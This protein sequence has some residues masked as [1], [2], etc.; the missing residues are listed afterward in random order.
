MR[1]AFKSVPLFLLLAVILVVSACAPAAQ[2]AAKPAAKAGTETQKEA[3]KTAPQSSKE[4][5][6][7]GMVLAQTG[8]YGAVGGG[9]AKAIQLEVD[10]VN[11]AGGV[12][13]HP[14]QLI[15][16]DDQSKAEENTALLR[17]AANDDKVVA[18]F[19]PIMTP[20]IAAALPVI[21]EIKVPTIA[22]GSVATKPEDPYI[23]TDINAID[24]LMN[25]YLDFA[26]KKGFKKVVTLTTT[27]DLSNQ[28]VKLVETLSPK[29]GL[30]LVGQERFAQTDQDV[31]PQL[32]K[33]KALNPDLLISW[34]T[35][36]AAVLLY[37]NSR[38]LGF[39]APLVY[40]TAASTSQW[41]KLAG[42]IPQEGTVFVGGAK[43]QIVDSLPDSDPFK[44]EAL[45]FR[46]AYIDKFNLTPAYTEAVAWDMVHQVA[47]GL[48]ANGPDRDKL[49]AYLE[50]I[51][52]CGIG[53]C[54][55]KTAT[56]HIGLD[57]SSMPVL[58]AKGSEWVLAK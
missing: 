13:G 21:R 54:Y 18:I 20:I 29:Y 22:I 57:I 28:A 27:E 44:K 10:R 58:T 52:F 24:Q 51:K 26:K 56:D 32:T 46:K 43:L 2:E 19:G 39:K 50:T 36:D 34:A 31:T 17:K 41:F 37:K 4:P 6:K 12:D 8:T 23:F 14:L 38:Q 35:G 49:R 7:I 47:D 11:A 1:R 42:D 53:F 40:N 9:M 55:N 48:K 5:Y 16:Y 30:E 45:A 3:P 33:L 15:N 25:V